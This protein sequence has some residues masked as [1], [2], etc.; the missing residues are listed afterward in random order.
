MTTSIPLTLFFF[1][2]ILISI[3]SSHCRSFQINDESLIVKTCNKTPYVNVCI[4]AIKS[5]PGSAT[6]TL[7]GL[8]EITVDVLNGKVNR[9]LDKIH[10]LQSSGRGPR[11]WLDSCEKK[12]NTMKEVDIPKAIQALKRGD[13]E[14]AENV[15]KGAAKEATNC[16]TETRGSLSSQN[17]S[18][19]DV[20]TVAQAVARQLYTN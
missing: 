15:A 13:G 20:A 4:E 14:G 1:L 7:R 12:Y 18:V 6:A 2:F 10:D 5:R 17:K 19:H 9:A 3:P 16:E 11:Q 8:A